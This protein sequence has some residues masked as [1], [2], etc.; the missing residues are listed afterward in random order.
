MEVEAAQ[1][2]A[3][4]GATGVAI[5]AFVA[6]VFLIRE[7]IKFQLHATQA[8]A[9]S[10]QHHVEALNKLAI[11][12]TRLEKSTDRNTLQTDETLKFMRNL[13][14]KLEQAVID[15]HKQMKRRDGDN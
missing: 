5:S 7:F 15:K 3:K 10:T 12:L 8:T 6:I 1:E 11:T 4:Y 14:G 2:L 13:N 9:K